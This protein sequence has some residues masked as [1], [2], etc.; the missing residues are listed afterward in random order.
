M[1]IL[2]KCRDPF[3]TPEFSPDREN[4]AG[5]CGK[6]QANHKIRAFRLVV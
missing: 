5:D 6:A 2:N 3:P 4:M 1:I